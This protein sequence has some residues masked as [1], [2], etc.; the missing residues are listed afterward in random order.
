MGVVRILFVQAM[1]APQASMM[2]Q[3]AR[4]K[5][6]S[7]GLKVPDKWQTPSG[8]PGAR[9]YAD[10]FKPSEKSTSP[11]PTAPPLFLPHSLNKYH[12]DVQKKMT[13]IVGTYMDGIVD[14]ICSAWSTWQAAAILSSVLIN[15]P[16]A[17]MGL[18]V[19]MPWTPLIMASGPKKSPAELK[20]TTTIANVMG[21]AWAAYTAT[22]KVPGLPWYP[23]F[24]AVPL[25]LA[26][27]M[28]NIP[29]NVMMLTQVTASVSA[30]TMKGQMIGAHAEPM[31][32]YHKEIFE[33]VCDAFE[34][35]FLIWQT[36]TMV[37]N[38]LGTGPVPGGT[39]VSPLPV[40]AGVGT[41]LPGGF[42]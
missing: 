10:A 12:T 21:T 18:I 42:T 41:M 7:F 40:V 25:P 27:P 19:G 23:A 5:F 34:K 13:N 9:H 6:S 26:P 38:V 4:V 24:T 30:S 3:L 36:S 1:P 39:P 16:T 35:C 37:T 32:M 29:C 31:A 8:D 14:A 28:P 17:S 20:Y 22:I 2:K 11:D 33:A 15:G